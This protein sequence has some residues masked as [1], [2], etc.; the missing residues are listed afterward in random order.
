MSNYLDLSVKENKLSIDVKLDSTSTED[1]YL[2][3]YS[4]ALYANVTA[5][6]SFRETTGS[7]DLN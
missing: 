3:S 4:N 1:P 2:Y 6:E 5:A 7:Q